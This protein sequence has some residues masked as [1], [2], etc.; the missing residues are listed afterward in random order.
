M[1]RLS[2]QC[3]VLI[4]SLAA[5]L[6]L[7]YLV[8]CPLLCLMPDLTPCLKNPQDLRQVDLFAAYDRDSNLSRGWPRGY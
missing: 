1:K 6:L 3:P 7:V 4:F 5:Y 2:K 8:L